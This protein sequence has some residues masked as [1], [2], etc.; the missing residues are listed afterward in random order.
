MAASNPRS[1][2]EPGSSA[3]GAWGRVT[4][5]RWDYFGCRSPATRFA[6]ER[7]LSAGGLVVSIV[8]SWSS[9]DELEGKLRQLGLVVCTD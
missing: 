5:S 3:Y 8:P 1:R 2:V 7:A 6:A 4:G 9:I